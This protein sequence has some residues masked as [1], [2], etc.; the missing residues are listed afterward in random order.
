[1][2]IVD[3]VLQLFT[4]QGSGLYFGEEVTETEHALQSAALAEQSGAAKELV[5]AALLHDI[6]H[7]LHGL[8]E[9]VAEKVST[10]GTRRAAPPGSSATSDR[11]SPI[12][13]DCTLRPSATPAPRTY[14]TIP[15]SHRRRNAV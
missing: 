3:R 2:T 12:P 10:A 1:M 13:C 7:L 14:D 11:P 15:S 9:D 4:E 8:G 6:G 5:A